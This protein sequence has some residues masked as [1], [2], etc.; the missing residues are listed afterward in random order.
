MQGVENA[1]ATARADPQRPVYHFLPPANWMNDPNGTIYHDGYYH[2]FYQH[3]PYGDAWD[4]MHWGHARSRDL[5]HW[6][7]LPIALWPSEELGEGHCF[8]G[9]AAVNADDVPMLFYTKVSSGPREERSEN[10]QWAAV[11]DPDWIRWQKHADNPILALDTHGGPRFEGDWRDPYI[12]HEAGRTFM[13]LGGAV[14]DTA[15]VALYEAE[16][17]TLLH[18]RYHG[19]LCE[20]PR[21][22]I[23]FFECPNF[24]KLDDTWILLT[25]PYR[26]VE[27]LTG[28]F[29]L[30]TLRFTPQ[31][32][33]IL[34]HGRNDAP[35][36]YATNTLFDESGRCILLG[37]V[38]GF[39]AGRGWN[40]CLSLPR[41]LTLG[42]DG[43]P[44]QA[45]APELQ[46]LRKGAVHHADI[47]LPNEGRILED[48]AGDALEIQTVL[49][50]GTARAAGLHVRGAADGSRAISL[51][52][53]GRTLQV[54]ENQVPISV[55]RAER[56][57]L[58]LFLDKS[59]LELFVNDGSAALTQVISAPPS[60]VQVAV[61][62]EEGDAQ[63]VMLDAW[64]MR[65][66]W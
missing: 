38:R 64:E 47:P 11:G 16:D 33:G 62:A 34:D 17:G 59:V 23:R 32:H 60:D 56:I 44:R 10:E 21:S 27:Y 49:E 13:V 7:H 31:Q 18:W 3:N 61:F 52:Y 4:H 30:E 24:F 8:S 51:R 14:E 50:L 29:D 22:Q 63:L 37:W 2:L 12:F 26:N 46:M 35:H 43:R 42:A 45:P 9:C 54:G 48:V 6:E 66:I 19:L 57:Q 39:P 58:R 36:F 1:A 53:D 25:S 28:A 65:S 40:G 41:V 55:D 20:Q 5:V 15:G